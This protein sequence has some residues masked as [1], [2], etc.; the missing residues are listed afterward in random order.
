MGVQNLQS[1]IESQC[2]GACV[3][4]DLLKIARS[5]SVRRVP[6]NR[7]N[8]KQ[9]LPYPTYNRL[10]LVLDGECCLDRLY[11][12]YFSDWV[13]G[14][15][16]YRMVQFLSLLVQ[17]LQGNNIDVAVFFNGALEPE[18]TTEWAKQQAANR[19]KI[20]QV[21]KHV[22]MKAT[23]PPKVWWI[24]PVCLRTCLRMAL[25]HLNLQVICTMD[26]HHQEVIAFCR[27][28]SFDGLMA[29]DAEYAIF[30]PP[31]YFSSEQ[32]K[33][34]YKVGFPN[35]CWPLFSEQGS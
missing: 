17:T 33:L 20:S 13:C 15:Q 5:V 32:M 24:P 28:N 6:N 12:G 19:K 26:D 8:Y 31:R 35:L 4:V 10:R 21:L 11:G 34:T 1:F 30:D 2:P 23:P 16:W 14:G 3:P 27:E 29:E 7:G 22:S 18:R 25:R 9:Q